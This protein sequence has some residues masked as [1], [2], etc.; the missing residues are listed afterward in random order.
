MRVTVIAT[1]FDSAYSAKEPAK[2]P[3][4]IGKIG[5]HDPEAGEALPGRPKIEPNTIE[6]IDYSEGDELELPNFTY[7]SPKRIRMDD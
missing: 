4:L 2:K 1:G 6:T 3:D 5:Q 7:R